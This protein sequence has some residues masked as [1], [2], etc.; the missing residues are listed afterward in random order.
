[1]EGV[2]LS[3]VEGYIQ[4]EPKLLALSIGINELIT[5]Y[6]A[7]NNA[8]ITC[9]SHAARQYPLAYPDEPKIQLF[10]TV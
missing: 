4:R 8:Q 10:S 3:E 5:A 6:E 9:S 7:D 1:M 2:N